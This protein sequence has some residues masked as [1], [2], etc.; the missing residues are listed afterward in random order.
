[1]SD[2]EQQIDWSKTTFEGSRKE[3]LRQTLKMSVRERLE[4]QE[5]LEPLHER[6]ALSAHARLQTP[7]SVI[8]NRVGESQA[9]YKSEGDAN[10]VALMGCT[11][12]PLAN[13]L[14]SLGVL[15]LLAA[16]HPDLKAAWRDGT[17]VLRTSLDRAA[18]ERF[19]LEEYLPTPVMAPWNGGSGFYQKDNKKALEAIRAGSTLRFSQYREE[20]DAV[21]ALLADIDRS[22]SPKSEAKQTLLMQVRGAL[23]DEALSWFD[24]AVLMSGG[25]PGYPPLLGTGGNDGR[26]DF[27]NNFMQRLL[28]VIHPETGAPTDAS[29]GWLRASLFGD[30]RPGLVDN[31]I[32]QFSPGQAGGANASAGFEGGATMNPWDFVLMIEG[33][34]MFA[35]AAVRRNADDPQGVLSYPFTVRAVGAGAG[36]VG[37][38]DAASSRA[39]GELWMPLWERA[40]SYMEIQALLSEG[41]VALGRRPARDA[42]DFVRAV[43][44]LGGYR[45][46]RSFQRYGLLMRSGKA[47]FA[48]PLE[49]VNVSDKSRVSLLDELAAGGGDWLNQ[50]RRFAQ[51]GSA[52]TRFSVLRQRLETAFFRLSG[53]EPSPAEVQAVLILLGEIQTSLSSSKKAREAVAPIP[54]LS[55]RWLLNANDGTPAFRITSAL[56]GLR[57]G[58]NAALPLRAQLFPVH[59]RFNQ[60]MEV[61]RKSKNAASDDKALRLRLCTGLQ[62]GL[63]EALAGLLVRR[64]WLAEQFEIQDKP[65][66]SASTASLGDVLN[67]LRDDSM[68]R[69]IAALLPGF[70]LCEVPPD[71]DRAADDVV[72]PAAFALLKLSMTPDAILRG[73]GLLREKEQLPLPAGMLALLRSCSTGSRAVQVASRRLRASGLSP[74]FEHSALPRLDGLNPLRVAAAL[75]IPLHF[76]DMG[77]LA[78]TVLNRPNPDAETA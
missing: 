33:A 58:A 44:R 43:H 39:R 12:T 40:A 16:R 54:R 51:G 38:D 3:Q 53:K 64:L 77:Q 32:G 23:S 52:A 17:F 31:A 13:Y 22:A 30:T 4:A 69:R 48:T 37:G 50:F 78:A 6:I 71:I 1:M 24:A 47:F 63:P 34:L 25:E 66:Q 20:L 10:E 15:R 27:T 72:A 19:L 57:G 36:N 60:W 59:P 42:L 75:L 5:Q 28:D 26:L 45:G 67:F 56:A 18:I 55:E 76:G 21:E 46:V 73:L 29:A 65:L 74:K 2:R 70:C 61:A 41:R 35:A 11:P 9:A 49:R 8:G 14:K 62:G 7:D 68:D